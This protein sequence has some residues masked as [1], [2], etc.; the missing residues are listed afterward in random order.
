MDYAQEFRKFISSQYLYA[1]VRITAGAVIPALILYQYGLLGS[2]M[3]VPLGAL[4]VGFTDNPGPIQHRRNAIFLSIGFNFV[5][6]MIAGLSRGHS[7]M[8]GIELVA[9]SMFF[10]L[11]GVYGN[12]ANSIGSIALLVFIFNI[13]AHLSPAGNDFRDILINAGWFTAGGLWYAV[14]SLLLHTLRPYKLI[15]QLLGESLMETARYLDVK[16]AFYKKD[17]QYKELYRSLMRHQI[18]IQQ[19]Q[20]ELREMLFKARSVVRESTSKGRVLMQMFLDSIDLFERIMTTQQDYEALHKEFE[21]EEILQVYHRTILEMAD[22]LNDIGLAIQDG[23]PYRNEKRIDRLIENAR[24]AFFSMRNKKL[25]ADNIEGFIKLRHILFSLQD[26]AERIKVLSQYTSYDRSISKALKNQPKREMHLDRFITRQDLDPNLL[27]DNLSLESS[28]FRHAA[29]LT[30][31]LVAGYVISLLFPLGHGYWILLTITTI[32]KPAYSI[33]KKRNGQR[34]IGTIT[35]A[36]LGFAA[37]F[38]T[39]DTT[40]LFIIMLLAMIISYSMLK[41]NYLVSSAGITLY[42]IIS[43]HFL[44]PSGLG[45]VLHDRVIDTAIGCVIAF[46]A[47]SFVLPVWEKEQIATY[48][49]QSIVANR[50]YFSTVSKAFTGNGFDITNYKVARKGAFVA[51][52]NMSDHFQRM[53]SEPKSK[54]YNLENYHQFVATSHLLTSGI[55]SLSYYAHRSGQQYGSMDFQPLVN[56]VE[57]QFELATAILDNRTSSVAEQK[58]MEDPIRQ[59]V[60]ELLEIRRDEMSGKQLE[61][62]EQNSVRKTL[63]DL[64]AITDQFQLIST[65]SAEQVKILDKLREFARTRDAVEP[66][67]S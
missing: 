44:N 43:F 67:P 19:H 59:K 35:G 47:S 50:S 54:Q 11:L 45:V 26:L 30:L 15:Q 23:L 1:G 37:I 24:D 39:E 2:M 60:L 12:R 25:N 66:Q 21:Q 48:L 16:A 52:A 55:A 53:M 18:A 65:I 13:D 49:E 42:V 8:I 38:I 57:A 61:E 31:A 34:I 56:Q 28:T 40:I 3:A 20:D 33:S 46:L 9:F 32:L 27:F 14:L 10:S 6:A 62:E 63:S 29:R 64:K 22:T 4:C 17:P 58:L 51:L 41:L 36:L 5:A 7:W